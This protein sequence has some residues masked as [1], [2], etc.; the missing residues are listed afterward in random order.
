MSKLLKDNGL[1]IVLV[2]LFAGSLV[3]HWLTGLNYHNA[4]LA[5]HGEQPIGALAFLSD[6]QFLATVFENWESEFLQMST[7]VVLTAFLF[8]RGSSESG[9][10]DEPP[11]DGRLSEVRA[12]PH[13]SPWLRGGRPSR[14]LYANS[15]GI[16]PSSC[17]SP[18]SSCTGRSAPAKPPR[19]CGSTAGPGQRWPNI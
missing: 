18:P 3:G 2:L 14:W 10:P 6:P 9:D 8:Q 17:S 7:Y 5:E 19:L 15:L 13:S 12:A 4:E 16:V 1:T 11:R